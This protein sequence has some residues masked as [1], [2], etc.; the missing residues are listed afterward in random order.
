MYRMDHPAQC[1]TLTAFRQVGIVAVQ[2]DRHVFIAIGAVELDL[3][4]TGI[5]LVAVESELALSARVEP[6]N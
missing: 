6:T 3:L 1:K 5:A 4:V 2:T